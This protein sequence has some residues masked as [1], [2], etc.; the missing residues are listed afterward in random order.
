[1]SY[2]RSCDFMTDMHVQVLSE[3]E[4]NTWVLTQRDTVS[5]RGPQHEPLAKLV[6]VFVCVC[7]CVC[8]PKSIQTLMGRFLGRCISELDRH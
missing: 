2:D 8:I 3:M 6:I 5:S 4:F 7:M 1:M